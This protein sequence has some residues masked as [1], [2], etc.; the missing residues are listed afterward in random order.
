[1]NKDTVHGYIE[2]VIAD[3]FLYTISYDLSLEQ[4]ISKK[5]RIE[6]SNYLSTFSSQSITGLDRFFK[7]TIITDKSILYHYLPFKRH[8]KQLNFRPNSVF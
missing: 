1:M 3:Y 2:V 4:R 7:N 5:D 6:Q 8:K